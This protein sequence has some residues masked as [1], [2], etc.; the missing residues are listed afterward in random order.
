MDNT[1]IIIYYAVSFDHV[2]QFV[3]LFIFN[4]FIFIING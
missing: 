1:I 2:D 4:I 3:L